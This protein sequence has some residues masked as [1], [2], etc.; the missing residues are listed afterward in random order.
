MARGGG[1]RVSVSSGFRGAESEGERG[2]SEGAVRGARPRPYPL[3]AVKGGRRERPRRARA[4]ATA[5]GGRR[6][7]TFFE[8]ALGQFFFLSFESFSLLFLFF[9]CFFSVIDLIEQANELQNL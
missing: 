2:E 5:R 9:F 3:E 4:V 7:C 6:P 8:Q 1:A